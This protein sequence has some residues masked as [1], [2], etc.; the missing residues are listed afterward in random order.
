LKCKVYVGVGIL[1]KLNV[2]HIGITAQPALL[3]Y[4]SGL[5]QSLSITTPISD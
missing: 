1:T 3:R 2:S 5:A 4:T